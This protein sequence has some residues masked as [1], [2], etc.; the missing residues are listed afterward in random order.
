MRNPFACNSAEH[1]VSRRQ[2]L[3]GLAA[4]TAGALALPAALQRAM[5]EDLKAKRKQVLFI[6]IDGGISQ[7]ESWDPKPNTQFGGPFRTIPTSVPGVHISELLEK[8]AKQMHH[9]AVVR[10][11]F[12]QDNAHSSAVARIQ[13]GDP[14]NRG[15]PYPYI[16]SAVAKFIGPGDSKLPP[17]IWIKPLSGGFRAED[18]GFLGAQYGCLALGDGRP[19]ENLLRHPS[20]SADVDAARNELRRKANDRFAAN[21]RKQD[22]DANAYAY[23]MA[24]KLMVRQDLFDESAYPARDVERYGRHALG[25]HLLQARRLLEAG[26]TFVKVNSFH[27]DTHGDNFNLHQHLVPRF[28]QPFAALIEDLAASGRLDHTLVVAMSEFGRTPRINGHVGRDHW[29]EAWSVAMAGCGLKRGAVIGKT[30]DKGVFVTDRAADVGHLFHTWFKALGIDPAKH[31]YDNA[32][33]PLPLANED[34][35]PIKEI[36]A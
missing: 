18:A 25:R 3:G 26:V 15:V 19:P 2:V 34:C 36:M 35:E 7:L 4:A 16:G 17:Y 1:M 27:W 14:K 5:A 23:D 24:A 6:W 28:D 12:T 20:V 22:N 11:M 31:E 29:P 32:G 33:Q 9:L 8:T 30:D 13:R 21:R 10:S